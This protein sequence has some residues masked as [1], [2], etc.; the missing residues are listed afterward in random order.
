MASEP[1]PLEKRMETGDASMHRPVAPRLAALSGGQVNIFDEMFWAGVT[2][3]SPEGHPLRGSVGLSYQPFRD[4][5]ELDSIDDVALEWVNKADPSR[6][7]AGA[8]LGARKAVSIKQFFRFCEDPRQTHFFIKKGGCALWLVRKTSGYVFEQRDDVPSWGCHRVHFEFVREATKEE[9]V[10]RTGVNARSLYWM[11]CSTPM[12]LMEKPLSGMDE[13][14]VVE[15]E[16]TEDML[17]QGKVVRKKKLEPVP[18]TATLDG[19]CA[20]AGAAAAEATAEAKPKKP[21]AKPKAAGGAGTTASATA[22]AAASAAAAN[23][24]TTL[25]TYTKPTLS[26]TP[27]LLEAKEAPLSVEQVEVVKVKLFEHEGTE[28]YYERTKHKLY[29]RLPNGSIGPYQGRWNPRTKAIDTTIPDS[30]E[31]D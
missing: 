22:S 7:E 27:A 23:D 1:I 31:E 3:K 8:P 15:P 6:P 16:P 13:P 12:E 2:Q 10:R 18:G 26:I 30:S 25:P 19:S 28:Y 11:E 29:K 9:G 24:Q 21:K 4:L 20:A 5:K 17:T 14:K